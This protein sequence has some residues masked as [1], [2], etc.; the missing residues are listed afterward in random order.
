MQQLDLLALTPEP[1]AQSI[2]SALA[3]AGWVRGPGPLVKDGVM[4]APKPGGDSQLTGPGGWTTTFILGV[5]SAVVIAA[6][7]AAV[8]TS[9]PKES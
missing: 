6:C 7:L 3:A 8:P 2:T 4:W 5:P 1:I 9:H